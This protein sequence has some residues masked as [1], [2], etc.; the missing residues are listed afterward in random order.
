MPPLCAAE[1]LT[2]ADSSGGLGCPDAV[3]VVPSPPGAPG[4]IGVRRLPRTLELQ[5]ATLRLVPVPVPVLVAWAVV[6]TAG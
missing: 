1:R 6:A 4:P 3:T 5:G 2:T